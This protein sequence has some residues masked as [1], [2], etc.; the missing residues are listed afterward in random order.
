MNLPKLAYENSQVS[1]RISM[2]L[3][4]NYYFYLGRAI[5]PIKRGL[6]IH[7]CQGCRGESPRHITTSEEGRL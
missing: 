5:F 2:K 4:A 7:G 3:H 1:D 6:R